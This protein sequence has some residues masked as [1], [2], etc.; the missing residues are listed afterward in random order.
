MPVA[1][2]MTILA[3]SPM[4]SSHA[5]WSTVAIWLKGIEPSAWI[6]RRRQSPRHSWFENHCGVTCIYRHC[7]PAVNTK[8]VHQFSAGSVIHCRVNCSWFVACRS[9]SLAG[10][11]WFGGQRPSPRL[12]LW[13]TVEIAHRSKR[14]RS[15]VLYCIRWWVWL[16]GGVL[17]LLVSIAIPLWVRYVSGERRPSPWILCG[18]V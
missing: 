2:G 13:S 5:T 18:L 9:N 17:P 16:G 14:I 1:I 11:L 3:H 7:Q 4:Y 15:V 12:C 8:S 6:P 10:L